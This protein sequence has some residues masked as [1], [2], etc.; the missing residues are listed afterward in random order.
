MARG[1]QSSH[2]LATPIRLE[3]LEIREVPAALAALDPSFGTGGNVSAV[4][5]PFTGVAL[6][7]DGRIVAVGTSN[8]DFFVARYNPN[9]TLDTTFDGDGIKTID[10]GGADHAAA[11]AI[12]ADGKIVVV[13]STSKNDNVA[14]ARLTD[15]GALD[16]SFNGTGLLTIDLA[17]AGE[18]GN[19]VAIQAD[20]KIVVAGTNGVDF[21]VMRVNSADGSLDGAFGS[22]GK[23]I[24]DVGGP[25]DS[26]NAVAIQSDGKIVATGNN[27]SDFAIVRLNSTD[28]S[29]DATFDTDG[30]ETVNMGGVDIARGLVIQPNTKIVVVGSNGGD[31]A[32]ARLNAANGSLDSS[33]DADGKQTVDI[34][35]ADDARAV[36]LQPDGKILVVG[37]TGNNASD[38]AVIRLTTAG[39]LDTTFNSTGKFSFDVT[40]PTFL[41]LGTAAVLSPQGRLIVAGQGGGGQVNGSLVRIPVTLEDPRLLAVGGS[42]NGQST[43]YAPDPATGQFNPTA[44]ATIAAFGSISVNVRTAVG[45]V[46]GDGF[47][48]TVLVTGPGTAI[49]VAVVSGKD[50]TT[51]LVS[52]FDPFTGDFTGGGFVSTADFDNDG[53]SDVVITPDQGG[54]PRVVIYSLAADNTFSLRTNFFGID[55]PNFRGGARTAAGDFNGD[56]IAD[57]AIAAGFQGGPRVALLDGST[58]L[59]ATRTKLLN[60]FFAFDPSLRNGVY[61]TIG[62]ADGDGFSDLFIGAGPGGSPRVLGLSGKTL[63][64]SGAVSAIDAPLANFF[65]AGNASNRGGVRLSTQDI[66]GDGKADLVTGTGEGQ[67]SFIRVY[68]GKTIGGLGEPSGFQDLNPYAGAVLANGVFVG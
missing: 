8:S 45:D 58:L 35:G 16:T 63:V 33:F 26:A 61:V 2:P 3:Q 36:Q 64:T 6:Q 46:N 56:G 4:G 41:D 13:G 17:G 1:K 50:N 66:D 62:D 18:A 21:A 20:G 52:P 25:A 53:R 30:I 39:A 43:I 40:G 27:S 10:F 38:T 44:A 15:T 14:V 7:A 67:A 37:D 28:G 19:A 49:R 48:D 55:D 47:E 24:I 22:G 59:T 23:K 29:A 11:V 57:L 34:S 42:L 32:I 68:F 12:Q 51:V 60:D 5:A 9:G 31:M 54:G 65:V